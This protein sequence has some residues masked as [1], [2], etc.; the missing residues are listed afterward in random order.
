MQV[1]IHNMVN[2]WQP[3]LNITFKKAQYNGLERSRESAG[4][5]QRKPS[6][7]ILNHHCFFFYI[8]TLLMRPTSV[9]DEAHS[10]TTRFID[11]IYI[12]SIIY[13]WYL[14]YIYIYDICIYEA[15]TERLET[16]SRAPL[17]RTTCVPFCPRLHGNPVP[18][19]ISRD[20]WFFFSVT[21]DWGWS[22]LDRRVCTCRSSLARS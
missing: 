17:I 13:I 4:P 11:H 10:I 15:D 16:W 9:W 18:R 21:A 6:G 8:Y 19:P 1:Q 7:S 12:I 2:W 3:N 20:A 14:W 5:K 22:R